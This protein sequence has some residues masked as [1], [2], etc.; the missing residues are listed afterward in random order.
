MVLWLGSLSLSMGP[1]TRM[2]SPDY[3]DLTDGRLDMGASHRVDTMKMGGGAE[4]KISPTWLKEH[5]LTRFR[6]GSGLVHEGL[7]QL[8]KPG[9]REGPQARVVN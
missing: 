2:W 7:T 4:V 3:N 9:W 6:A 1:Y 5:Q 8:N